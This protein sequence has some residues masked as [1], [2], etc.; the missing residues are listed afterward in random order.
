MLLIAEVV[1]K[2]PSVYGT[3]RFITVFA[4]A[5]RTRVTFHIVLFSFF[6]EG[7]LLVPRPNPKQEDNPLTAVPYCLFSTFAAVLCMWRPFALS[8]NMS[9]RHT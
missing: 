2:F 3:R 8:I 9:M 7:L 5:R 6:A 1:N 4:R